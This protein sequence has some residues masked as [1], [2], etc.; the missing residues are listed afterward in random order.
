LSKGGNVFELETSLI[1]VLA[2]SLLSGSGVFLHGVRDGRIK[3]N[4][5]N[6]ITEWVPAVLAGVLAAY[7]V[8][9]H[10]EWEQSL[11]YLAVLVA[12]NNGREVT[13]AL[14]DRFIAAMQFMFGPKGGEK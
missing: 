13:S 1:H 2:P 9:Q 4:F 14:K 12:S 3:G 5:L 10:K 7:Y 8:A 6:F 11:M